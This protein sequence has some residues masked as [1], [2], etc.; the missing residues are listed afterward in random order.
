MLKSGDVVVVPL[1]FGV[2]PDCFCRSWLTECHG[3]GILFPNLV[4]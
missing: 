2:E 3:L 4:F 1:K